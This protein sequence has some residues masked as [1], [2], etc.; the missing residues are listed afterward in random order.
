MITIKRTSEN[1]TNL[2][3]YAM[4]K[5]AGRMIKNC[6][7]DFIKV[8]KWV[9]YIDAKDDGR[10]VEVLSLLADDGQIYA[11]NSKN[12]RRDFFELLDYLDKDQEIPLLQII[13]GTTKLG[14]RFVQ[15]T[16]VLGKEIKDAIAVAVDDGREADSGRDM[17]DSARDEQ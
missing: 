2:E 4:I 7:G 6:E 8:K 12:F 3:K 10:E 17:Y 13:S 11:T 1:L 16:P 15:F 5:K 9:D 14:R